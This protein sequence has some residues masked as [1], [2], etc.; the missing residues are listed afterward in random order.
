MNKQMNHMSGQE[1]AIKDFMQ[2]CLV[3]QQEEHPT[4]HILAKLRKYYDADRT[5]VFEV[6]KEYT[7]AG[8]TWEWCGEGVAWLSRERSR[9]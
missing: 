2:D 4:Y 1:Q 7:H 6:N 9:E 3:I 5:Y 8:N